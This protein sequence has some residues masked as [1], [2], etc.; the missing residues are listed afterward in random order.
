MEQSMS[1]GQVI[2]CLKVLSF[3]I[4]CGILFNIN[5]VCNERI[6]N[7]MLETTTTPWDYL[8]SKLDE[9][10][11]DLATNNS[12]KNSDRKYEN[13]LGHL[14]EIYLDH[15][16][17][18]AAL[19]LIS[20]YND[21]TQHREDITR[22]Y[23][24]FF[25]LIIYYRHQYD[26]PKL[27][28]LW[29]NH[30]KKFKNYASYG[31]LVILHDLFNLSYID[32]KGK[33]EASFETA[34][35]N[36][37]SNPENP[38]YN[39][40]LADLF[41]SICEIYENRLE[42]LKKIRARYEDD[43]TRSAMKA[44]LTEDV[45][46]FHCTYG[47]ILSVCEKFDEADKEFNLAIEA[48]NSDR[49]DYSLR[50]GRYN[51]YRVINQTR[52]QAKK[53]QDQLESTKKDVDS[54]KASIISSVETVGIFSGI[55]AFVIG[56][57]SITSRESVVESGLLIL[58]LMGGLTAAL[59]SFSLLLHLGSGKRERTGIK[60]LVIICSVALSI[61]AIMVAGC[62]ESDRES[63]NSIS[64]AREDVNDAQDDL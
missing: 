36:I 19:N 11:I 64:S 12:Y 56:T 57:L 29:K 42:D 28:K 40:A 1:G 44:I 35:K 4:K 6:I 18:K 58:T 46:V 52:M 33:I 39:H 25:S 17:E 49:K 32:K 43:A 24:A 41:A 50:M 53:L 9:A 51:Y 37:E 47:R 15:E 23:S 38:G 45:P 62:Y 8:M 27:N 16:I 60:I 26:N 34:K 14:S 2:P 3:P 55:V 54:A 10:S 59:S 63:A 61:S 7:K 21:K 5:K 31:H 30:H 48:E 13:A 22:E 20:N